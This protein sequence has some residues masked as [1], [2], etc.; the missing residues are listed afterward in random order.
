[1]AAIVPTR[2]IRS[3]PPAPRVRRLV[4]TDADYQLFEAIDRHGPLPSNYLYTFTKHLR[5][6]RTHLQNRLTEFYNGDASGPFLTR[7]PQQFASY[8][9]RYQHVVYD[10]SRRA[11][12]VLAERGTL[13]S[14][15]QARCD[16][17]VHRLM[18]ACVG[19]SLELTAPAIGLRYIPF[20]EI[21]DHPRCGAARLAANPFA[22]PVN[23]HG[24]DA[25]VP[26]LV[27]G[28]E[29]PG[30]GFR[31]FA[32]E[33]DRNTES[34]ERRNLSQSSFARKVE[35]Y[36][37]ALREQRYRA[38][39]GLPNL[40]V[41]TITTNATHARKLIEHLQ[42]RVPQTMHN[43]F[44]VTTDTTFGTDWSVPSAPLTHLLSESW[45]T[46]S[47]SRNLSAV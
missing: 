26:D 25:V 30:A 44:A 36:V 9:A 46:P 35:G 20:Q 10:L 37:A 21:L 11:K 27:F 18:S 45:T 23:G 42:T 38:W 14:Y 16:P 17:F 8:R 1:M 6:D 3:A 5:R 29:Y 34:I 43:H 39:W 33:I 28:L 31:F 19:A 32:V 47:G 40:H 4:L 24:K 13:T 41:L 2:R 22:L 15:S 7:P 12:M